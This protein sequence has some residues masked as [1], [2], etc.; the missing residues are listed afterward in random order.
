MAYLLACCAVWCP[1]Q[2]CDRYPAPTTMIGALSNQFVVE[3][4]IVLG[5]TDVSHGCTLLSLRRPR[6]GEMPLSAVT[7]LV[8]FLPFRP[9]RG[10]RIALMRPRLLRGAHPME[11]PRVLVD[12]GAGR[13]VLRVEVFALHDPRQTEQPAVDS[14][15]A[16]PGLFLPSFPDEHQLG[17]AAGQRDV[18]QIPLLFDLLGRPGPGEGQ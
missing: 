9:C 13:L 17:H 7:A 10:L 3:Q 16:E 11:C 18:D 4:I 12:R 14:T 6:R 1:H 5:A 8:R 15:S 2:G